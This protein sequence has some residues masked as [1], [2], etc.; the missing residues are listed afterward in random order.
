[1]IS[2]EA[3]TK[4]LRGALELRIKAGI[5]SN[6]PLCI[7]DLAEKI[8]IEVMF[9]EVS[10]FEGMYIKKPRTVLISSLRPSGRQAFTCAHEMGH[11]YFKHGTSVDEISNEELSSLNEQE[12]LVDVFA[13]YMLMPPWAIEKAFKVRNLMPNKSTP[14]ELYAIACQMNVGYSTLIKHLLWS[15]KLITKAEAD[16]ILKI[17][18][19]NIKQQLYPELNGNLVLVDNNWGY[20]PVDLEVG[21]CAAFPMGTLIEGAGIET[22]GVTGK[23]VIAKGTKTG[24]FRAESKRKDWATFIRVKKKNFTGR[25]IYRHLEEVPDDFE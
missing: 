12:Q 9:C 2:K 11:W 23:Y 22:I 18:P 6:I 19:K 1:M 21:D 14:E 16:V 7:F 24:I 5:V 4:A 3:A 20:I 15:L 25:A 17:S 10:S 8:G 13:S